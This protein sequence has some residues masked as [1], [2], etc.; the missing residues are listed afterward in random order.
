MPALEWGKDREVLPITTGGEEKPVSE[1][2]KDKTS[3]RLSW[4]RLCVKVLGLLCR[5]RGSH[6]FRYRR[7][8]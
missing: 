6:D 8:G 3:S 5:D 1:H 4:K 7:I 2:E